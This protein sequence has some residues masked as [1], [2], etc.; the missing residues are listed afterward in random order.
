MDNEAWVIFQRFARH[1]YFVFCGVSSMNPGV[2]N[3]A[4]EMFWEMEGAWPRE[5]VHARVRG[6][7]VSMKRNGT[8]FPLFFSI[9]PSVPCRVCYYLPPC[10]EP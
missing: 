8:Y 7:S 1:E 10:I 6:L 9:S 2:L 4:S 5:G 3:S